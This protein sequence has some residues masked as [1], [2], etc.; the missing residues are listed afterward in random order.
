[1]FVIGF[2]ACVV[3]IDR[4]GSQMFSKW[5]IRCWKQHIVADL[6][7]FLPMQRLVKIASIW[8][9]A[10]W[11]EVALSMNRPMLFQVPWS[12]KECQAAMNF[13]RNPSTDRTRMVLAR[14]TT[15]QYEVASTYMERLCSVCVHGT[16][17]LNIPLWNSKP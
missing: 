7:Q 10:K 9:P 1:M 2:A 12:R 3:G 17:L 16:L 13:R 6:R 8:W 11:N 14:G 15:F 5:F 4:R